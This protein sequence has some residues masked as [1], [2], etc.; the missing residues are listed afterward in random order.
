MEFSPDPRSLERLSFAIEMGQGQ[1][2]LMVVRCNYK[3]LV[4][5]VMARLE[6]IC[7][8]TLVSV[9]VDAN[10]GVLERVTEAVEQNPEVGCV[11]VRFSAGMDREVLT[12]IFGAANRAREVFRDRIKRP[13]VLWLDD[14]AEAVFTDAAS[15]LESLSTG[16]SLGFDLDR[17]DL[18]GWVRSQ[19]DGLVG[20]VLGGGSMPTPIAQWKGA[21]R[22]LGGEDGLESGELSGEEAAD[23]LVLEG[24]AN[25][26]EWLRDPTQTGLVERAAVAYGRSLELWLDVASEEDI[27]LWQRA[28]VIQ[29]W[30]A[31]LWRSRG[32]LARGKYFDYWR[33]ALDWQDWAIATFREA[34]DVSSVAR[35]LPDLGA[36]LQRLSEWE[37]LAMA[38]E[39]LVGL[40]ESGALADGFR[41]ARGYG[42]LGKVALEH[43][44]WKVSNQYFEQALEELGDFVDLWIRDRPFW[45]WLMLSRSRALW[46]LGLREDAL[47]TIKPACIEMESTPEGGSRLAVALLNQA[48]DFYYATGELEEA[49]K[50]KRS[51]RSIEQQFRLKAFVGA[52][53]VKA[54][55]QERL[56]Q[57]LG[58]WQ[59][60]AIA[61]EI[62]ASG[63][64][65]DVDALML[66]LE[67]TETRLT[68]ICGFSGVGKSSLVAAGLV[69]AIA[70]KKFGNLVRTGVPVVVRRYND[71][72]QELVVAFGHA[73]IPLIKR[74][75]LLTTLFTS[76]PD[77]LDQESLL[78]KALAL[79]EAA[80]AEGGANAKPVLILD[81]FEDF[82]TH[83]SDRRD[84]E[85]LFNFLGRCLKAVPSLDIVMSIRRDYVHHLLDWPMLAR[86]AGDGTLSDQ[87][88]FLVDDF[89][90]ERAIAVMQR[91]CEQV[92][93]GIDSPSLTGIVDDL[94]I[95]E[96]ETAKVRPIELQLVGAQ[97][98][99]EGVRSL[100]KYRE[101]GG[102]L[103]LVRN[104]LNEVKQDCGPRLVELAG[105]VLVLMVG[106]ARRGLRPAKGRSQLRSELA[107]YDLVAQDK[108]LA[109]ILKVFVGA[110]IA[111]ELPGEPEPKFQLVHDYL[112]E[113][114]RDNEQPLFQQVLAAAL[115]KRE[116]AER[117]LE[118]VLIL[119]KTEEEEAKR[120][121]GENE[122]AQRRVKFSGVAATLG[123]VMAIGLGAWATE[124][125]IRAQQSQ[126]REKVLAERASKSEQDLK[127]EQA[128]LLRVRRQKHQAEKEVE[129]TSSKAE[130]AQEKFQRR[131]KEF[132]RQAIE[133]RSLLRQEKSRFKQ[134]QQNLRTAILLS[135]SRQHALQKLTQQ[136][137]TTQNT[138]LD[139]KQE[140][141][142]TRSIAKQERLAISGLR[143]N[144]PLSGLIRAMNASA[145]IRSQS[146][147]SA[148]A[149]YALDKLLNA[150][151]L[152]ARN[153]LR[154]HSGSII[155]VDI[156]PDGS[157]IV[158]ASSDKTAII[159]DVS[160]EKRRTLEGHDR[161]V[162]S[163][164]FSPDGKFVVTA[165]ANKAMIWSLSNPDKKPTILSGHA[166]NVVSARFSPDNKTI[167]TASSDGTAILWDRS[168]KPLEILR[169]Q[170][171]PV[172]D[173]QFSPD[174]T[175]IVTVLSK[176]EMVIWSDVGSSNTKDSIPPRDVIP[177][178]N[179][180]ISS[181]TFSQD[182]KYIVTTSLDE[183]AKLWNSSG[184]L[185]QTLE[186]HKGWVW[187]ASFHP[188]DGVIATTS[189]DGTIKIWDR[190]GN[191]LET[192][193][194]HSSWVRGVEFSPNGLQMITVSDDQ[195]AMIWERG[196]NASELQTLIEKGIT[197]AEF[198]PD[199]QNIITTSSQKKATLWDRDG[200]ILAT[201]PHRS[202]VSGADFSSDGQT[203]ATTSWDGFVALWSRE[204]LE[205]KA[206]KISSSVILGVDFSPDSQA[207]VIVIG[208]TKPRIL[209]LVNGQERVLDGH[210]DIVR[211]AD[212]SSD[213]KTIVTASDD[214]T[215]RL[216]NRNGEAL[217]AIRGKR[218][219][220]LSARFSP[221][222]RSI[223]TVSGSTA[224]LL[225]VVNGDLTWGETL[226]GHS[227]FVLDANFS[228][229]GS[230]IVTAS[231]DGT[232]RVWDRI[233]NELQT[234]SGHQA[235]VLSTS[236]SPD[237]Q[238]IITT[239]EDDTAKL[240]PAET[241]D[242][243]LVKGCDWL[244]DYLTTNLN[245]PEDL[246]ERCEIILNSPRQN[247]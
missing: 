214:G 155:D 92:D 42:F 64:K 129:E 205:G 173:I 8:V 240:W 40:S 161:T 12:Q 43:K 121:R 2:K 90:R 122:A 136:V 58:L 147:G 243:L 56:E 169:H 189:S 6:E 114:I 203:L 212:F 170:G 22:T 91:L 131:E 156:S 69:P 149:E 53:Q 238:T 105:D 110:G 235:S 32:K 210:K 63:R 89:S 103:A 152:Q 207:L 106:D 84:H 246:K 101:K 48:R 190:K 157:S 16:A 132:E 160:G 15:D 45:A 104:Y 41:L 213:G 226:L 133:Q 61:D 178:H 165:S 211:S 166:K 20:M 10:V 209:N 192:L 112:A 5:A 86:A 125:G 158:T 50:L 224:Q 37:R 83:R 81:Q 115:A 80:P 11:V 237:G 141:D 218:G 19:V 54:V 93:F 199:G 34:G 177:A 1:F 171:I 107:E 59:K 151:K 100:A 47:N 163:A 109:W 46:G 60:S 51:R 77:N 33:V 135:Q 232:A 124:R 227:G 234:L 88:L 216:W 55:R 182:G 18:L 193:V 233:G 204:S 231:S 150:P 38:A 239:S 9:W 144:D 71:W 44:N 126:N 184:Q 98:E 30:L 127:L 66:R 26:L 21:V 102:K 159:W 130:R 228:P 181:V 206:L 198:S 72:R 97:L 230:T 123:L 120:L 128:S 225:N 68:V 134:V 140:L 113:F 49:F 164:K 247:S 13:I 36:E 176:G 195:T 138:L 148:S 99:A 143:L 222:G 180:I 197:G 52:G 145:I 117:S 201:F 146:A 94:A 202:T 236:F 188:K 229:D 139:A 223:I 196:R 79:Y 242:S 183:T 168:G 174:G 14:A 187:S 4:D 172:K 87:A 28:G 221:D 142:D 200:N 3:P 220:V 215:I 118:A 27:E 244:R 95:G 62:K 29:V 167:A 74:P 73:L 76:N 191:E 25:W 35:F 154:G 208:N 75:T 179:G 175:S 137:N 241:L 185:L 7:P 116:E 65:E 162:S 39:E 219:G 153:Q 119:K 78:L 23:V 186:G 17:G 70:S 31:E 82:F 67:N 96:G 85:P 111:F 108:D 57:D 194:G 245:A 217:Q 24:R